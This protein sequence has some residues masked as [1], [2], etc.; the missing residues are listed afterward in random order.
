MADC[1]TVLAVPDESSRE[2]DECYAGAR[3]P[4]HC[5]R[6]IIN[7]PFARSKTDFAAHEADQDVNRGEPLLPF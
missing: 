6:S 2:G 1:E 5:H 3:E 4:L 7:G